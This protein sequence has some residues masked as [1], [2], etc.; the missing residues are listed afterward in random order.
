MRA[1]KKIEN[2]EKLWIKIRDLIRSITRT[3]GDYD[4]K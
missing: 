3:S 4:E 1:Q 2:Y